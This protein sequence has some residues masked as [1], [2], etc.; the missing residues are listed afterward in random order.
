MSRTKKESIEMT[1]SGLSVDPMNQMPFLILKDESG[2]VAIPIWIGM[3]EAG[4]IATQ[5]ENITLARPMTHDLLKN[6][7]DQVGVVVEGVEICDLKDNTFFALIHLRMGEKILEVDARPSD[8]IALALRAGAP[9]YVAREVVT[10]SRQVDLSSSEKGGQ[11]TEKEKLA[12]MLEQMNGEDF[13][14][15]KQ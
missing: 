13:G 10:Q 5:L 11:A 6:I 9:I 8:A 2:N 3:L 14:K 4:A 12:E 7:L 15:Y 1:I